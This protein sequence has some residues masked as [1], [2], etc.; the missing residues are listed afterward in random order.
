[1]Y[2][3]III[4]NITHRSLIAEFRHAALV[5][6]DG[7]GG[8]SDGTAHNDVIGANFLGGGGSHDPLLVAHIAVSEADAG[9]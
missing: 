1:M 5:S 8:G 6:G 2:M 9:G 7:I 4:P 3:Q